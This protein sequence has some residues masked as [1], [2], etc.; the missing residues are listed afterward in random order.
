MQSDDALGDRLVLVGF[1][2]DPAE[3]LSPSLR[4]A[5]ARA[6]GGIVVSQA[7]ASAVGKT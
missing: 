2:C 5:W 7:S 6:G 3:H 4:E 1:G